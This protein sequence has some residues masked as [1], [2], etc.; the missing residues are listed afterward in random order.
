MDILPAAIQPS[1]RSG[2]LPDEADGSGRPPAAVPAESP[3]PPIAASP[4]Q[5][6]PEG[7]RFDFNQGC[8][9]TLPHRTASL[10]RVRI[11]DLDTG[12]ILFE[13]ENKGAFVNSAKRWFVRFGIEVWSLDASMTE[14]RSVLAH[15]Y[16][17]QGCDVLIQFP[18][19]TLGDTL[20]WFPYAAR[21]SEHHPGCRVTCALSGLII[22]L[23]R[24]AYPDLRLATHEELIEQRLSVCPRSCRCLA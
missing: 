22:P 7:I 23:L 3:Y 5:L 4:T 20:A 8:R 10:W 13:S 2:F 16:D 11:R 9:I 1:V 6:G 15:D 21:F 18:V 14:P 24:D 12:N 17:A 19:G